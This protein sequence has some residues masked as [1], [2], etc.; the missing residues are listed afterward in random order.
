[1]QARKLEESECELSRQTEPPASGEPNPASGDLN[2]ASD[3]YVR[4]NLIES[5]SIKHL[6]IHRRGLTSRQ[7]NPCAYSR[8]SHCTIE[9]LLVNE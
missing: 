1:M 4:I 3:T 8:F 9:D 5:V 7:E 6:S 2:P